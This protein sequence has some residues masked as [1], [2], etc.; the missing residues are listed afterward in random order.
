M[1]SCMFPAPHLETPDACITPHNS[2]LCIPKEEYDLVLCHT[3]PHRPAL[4]KPSRSSRHRFLRRPRLLQE[5]N[6][7]FSFFTCAPRL[8]SSLSS[9]LY[10]RPLVRHPATKFIPSLTAVP[11][12]LSSVGYPTAYTTTTILRSRFSNLG[13]PEKYENEFERLPERHRSRA[14]V[15]Q[16]QVQYR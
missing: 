7:L 13:D 11:A 15:V 4:T 14:S 10:A 2:E 6:L 12:L 8:F 3:Q 5:P 1:T 16:G 9:I